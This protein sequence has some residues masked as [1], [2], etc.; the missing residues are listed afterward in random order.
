MHLGLFLQQARP[1]LLAKG[2]L[3][4]HQLDIAIGVVDLGRGRVDLGEKINVG[5][6][7]DVLGHAL[8][9]EA[10]LVRLHVQLQVGLGHIR[11]GDGEIDNVARG[12]VGAG[13]LGPENYMNTESAGWLRFAREATIG[14]TMTSG[15]LAHAPP[16]VASCSL[17]PGARR[18]WAAARL[19]I[20][21]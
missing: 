13:A 2:F 1:I 19:K 12:V 10:Q 6:V 14:S 18:S 15:M 17:R 8:A 20:G 7:G 9:Q 4:K 11:G 16:Y 21:G 3:A 5:L